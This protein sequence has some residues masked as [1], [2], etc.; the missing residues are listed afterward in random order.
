[1]ESLTGENRQLCLKFGT[2][3]SW[4]QG[5]LSFVLGGIPRRI[6]RRRRLTLGFASACSYRST[7]AQ[8][9]SGSAVHRRCVRLLDAACAWHRGMGANCLIES[10]RARN[11][12]ASGVK[13]L[14]YYSLSAE[15][16]GLDR[17]LLRA[18]VREPTHR[19][20]AC[21][22]EI[23]WSINQ[24]LVGSTRPASGTATYVVSEADLIDRLM[25]RQTDLVTD[26][27]TPVK[28]Y[29]LQTATGE[30]VEH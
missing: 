21:E 12:S 4:Q 17:K 22:D 26:G 10:R 8:Q 15:R 14:L 30:R 25:D 20:R 5:T 19:L 13:S 6:F 24:T 7:A 11:E 28:V 3:F 29:T 16:Q 2:A 9:R 23:W 27:L 1:M 18:A